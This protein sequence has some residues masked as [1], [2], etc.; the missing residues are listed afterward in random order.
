MSTRVTKPKRGRKPTYKK[1]VEEQ[2][3]TTQDIDVEYESKNKRPSNNNALK[4]VQANGLNQTVLENFFKIQNCELEA[5]F[6]PKHIKNLSLHN[7]VDNNIHGLFSTDFYDKMPPLEL[8]PADSKSYYNN[9]KLNNDVEFQFNTGKS[10]LLES[11]HAIHF[12]LNES[13][14]RNGFVYNTGGLP[15]TMGWCPLKFENRKYLFLSIVD[16]NSAIGEFSNTKSI[17]TVLEISSET[18]SLEINKQIVLDYVVKEIEFSFVSKAE[19]TLLKLTLSN[20]TVEI[21]K[22]DSGFFSNENTKSPISTLKTGS[23]S[24]EIPNKHLLITSS[25]FTST[26]TFVFGTNHGYIGQF[27]IDN[28]KLDYLISARIPAITHIKSTFPTQSSDDFLTALVEAADFNNYLVRLPIP[29]K[30]SCLINTFKVFDI[31]ANNKEL[32]FDKNSIFLSN[33]NSFINVEWPITI[34]KICIDNPNS[35]TKF[36]I[37]NDDDINCLTNQINYDD[38]ILSDG[39]VLLTGHTNGSIRLANFLN[40]STNTEK[41]VQV[42]T[43]K[44]LQLNKSP[45]TDNKYW[46]DLCYKVDKIGE[47]PVVKSGGKQ[48][49]IGRTKELRNVNPKELCPLRLSMMGN[50]V[51]SIWGN[52]LLIIEQLTL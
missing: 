14:L 3:I 52:G 24:F 13:N 43:I 42:S 16:G 27:T 19:S 2:I 48:S 33:F 31:P 18:S 34:K 50:N 25:A 4:F 36:K 28:K 39:F 45:V 23:T 11:N 47:L 8:R 40:L 17:L 32:Q 20:G 5:G 6:L 21:W 1:D 10:E 51:A 35:I 9:F 7:A 30:K 49:A 46:L 37:A 29:N 15:L 22:V 12:P 44:I 38:G 26:N 41:K